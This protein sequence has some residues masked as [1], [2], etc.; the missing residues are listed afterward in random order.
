[1]ISMNNISIGKNNNRIEKG[2]KENSWSTRTA[3]MPT[4]TTAVWQDHLLWGLN[5]LNRGLQSFFSISSDRSEHLTQSNKTEFLFVC[6]IVCVRVCSRDK[7]KKDLEWNYK[8]E[9]IR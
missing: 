3:A 7:E 9:I 8:I 2:S 1:M 6:L 4:A 5:L